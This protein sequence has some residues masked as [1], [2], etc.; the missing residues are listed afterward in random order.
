MVHH[1]P[2]ELGHRPKLAPRIGAI[3]PRLPAEVIELFR[4]IPVPDIGDA[5]GPLY[6]LDPGIRPVYEPIPRLIGQALTVKAPPADNLTIHGAFGMVLPGDVLVIDWRGCI[7]FCGSGADSLIVPRE[8]GLAGIVIDGGWRD[9]AAL[10]EANFPLFAR[11]IS[12]TSPP[13][14]RPGEINVPVACGGVIVE[15]GDLIIADSE[16]AVV[17]PLWALETIAEAFRTPK[18]AQYTAQ[19][20]NRRDEIARDRNAFFAERVRAFGGTMPSDEGAS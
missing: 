3:A 15:P 5:I 11:A 1:I 17:I 18:P 20:R 12:P 16:G 7:D 19:L 10:R 4:G 9:I 8:A 13:K 2:T 14:S 6:T